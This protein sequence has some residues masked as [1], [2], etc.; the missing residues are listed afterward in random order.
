M[1]K[2]GSGD[3]FL[4]GM[5]SIGVFLGCSRE[6]WRRVLTSR[7]TIS[8][9]NFVRSGFYEKAVRGDVEVQYVNV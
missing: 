9:E 3:R 2:F 6:F 5:V 8:G 7:I 1:T 4:E